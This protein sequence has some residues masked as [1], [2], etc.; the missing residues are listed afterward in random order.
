MK[1]AVSSL[2]HCEDAR[3][4]LEHYQLEKFGGVVREGT[5][6]CRDRPADPYREIVGDSWVE[7]ELEFGN[8]A[9]L[10]KHVR[11]LAPKDR[12]GFRGILLNGPRRHEHGPGARQWLRGPEKPE[13]SVTIHDDYMD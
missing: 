11:Q 9:E 12:P 4:T 10:L 2:R 6:M 1:F 3:K 5:W 13:W 7:I 8:L